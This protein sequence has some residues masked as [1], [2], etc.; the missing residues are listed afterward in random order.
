LLP[1]HSVRRRGGQVAITSENN[2]LLAEA[3]DVFFSCRVAPAMLACLSARF[4]MPVRLGRTWRRQLNRFHHFPGLCGYS[5][6][7]R[8][9]ERQRS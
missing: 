9:L 2:W 1:A 3:A 7:V 6:H 4:A 5:F 8:A